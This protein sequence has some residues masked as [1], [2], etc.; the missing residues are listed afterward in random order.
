[1]P[2]RALSG[3]AYPLEQSVLAIDPQNAVCR[4]SA[5]PGARRYPRGMQIKKGIGEYSAQCPPRDARGSIGRHVDV[6]AVVA[7]PDDAGDEIAL[8]IDS[9]DRPI[10]L[11]SWAIEFAHHP[12]RDGVARLRVP[13]KDQSQ[14]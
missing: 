13:W 10:W 2:G 14:M 4:H 9:P 3:K 5:A 8:G 1:M 7:I 11:D 6:G 12:L